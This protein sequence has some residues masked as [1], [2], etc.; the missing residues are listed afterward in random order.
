MIKVLS[1][2]D[3]YV[4]EGIHSVNNISYLG[5]VTKRPMETFDYIIRHH[6]DVIVY[7]TQP[8]SLEHLTVY[9]RIRNMHAGKY[10]PIILL[11]N[12]EDED[13]YEDFYED[14]ITIGLNQNIK[15]DILFFHIQ[16]LVNRC[17]EMRKSVLL[18]DRNPIVLNTYRLYLEGKYRVYT[19]VTS[20][21]AANYMMSET[22]DAIIV[23]IERKDTRGLRFLQ[24]FKDNPIW[25]ETP[26]IAQI[27]AENTDLIP[28]LLSKGV[29]YC[30]TKPIE[31][32]ILIKHLSDILNEENHSSYVLEPG[33]KR[34]LLVDKFG[35]NYQN[36]KNI[37]DG[38][39]ECIH[40]LPGVRAISILEVQHIDAI[41]LNLD[42]G[43]FCL[44]KIIDRAITKSI[45]VILYTSHL[46]EMHETLSE[47][48]RGETCINC[49]L[50]LPAK[51]IVLLDKLELAI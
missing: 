27:E 15:E 11:V 30:L 25:S 32:D 5:G 34:I 3:T 47:K 16:Q 36:I 43:F 10:I 14:E 9:L 18:V 22:M 8:G 45:P 39:Y 13:I 4:K 38:H 1:I 12:E 44:N 48:M 21:E 28:H 26:V 7:A 40:V 49:I 37:L 20:Q 42:N 23:G 51:R 17:H 29:R 46:E 35:V 2:G 41:I 33:L 50:E 19:A 24:L 31:K 6:P